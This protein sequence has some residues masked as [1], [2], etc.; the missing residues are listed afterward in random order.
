MLSI[1]NSGVSKLFKSIITFSQTKRNV[2]RKQWVL[3]VG[4]LN[5]GNEVVEWFWDSVRG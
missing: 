3:G 5:E 4:C 2:S 1:I